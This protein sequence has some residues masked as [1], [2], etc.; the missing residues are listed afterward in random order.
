MKYPLSALFKSTHSTS[1][2]CDI[3]D[4]SRPGSKNA[5]SILIILTSELTNIK[6]RLAK[7]RNR[8][9]EWE[10]M[11]V[12]RFKTPTNVAIDSLLKELY[13]LRDASSRREPREYAQRILRTVRNAKLTDFA[14]QLD[15]IFDELELTLFQAM[16]FDRLGSINSCKSRTWHC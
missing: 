1:N 16:M 8:L 10:R 6:K 12:D 2:A 4:S 7:L 14:N 11:L 3:S 9:G 13:T 15:F 5:P